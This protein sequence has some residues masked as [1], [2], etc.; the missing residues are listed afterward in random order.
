M[1]P[2]T[3]SPL[4]FHVIDVQLSQFRQLENEIGISPADSQRLATS[5]HEEIDEWPKESKRAFVDSRVI[6]LNAR[7]DELQAFQMWMDSSRASTDPGTVRARVI[8]QNYICFV[9]LNDACFRSL[10]TLAVEGSVTRRCADYLMR[11]GVRA[12]RN[13][14]AHSNW[15]Y[16][17]AFDGLVYWSKRKLHG[18]EP[19]LRFEVDQA[20]LGFW[21]AL[22]RTVA[23][24]SYLTLRDRAG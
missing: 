18:N 20:Q 2:Q 10:Q 5:I 23:Y 3:S 11:D 7:I 15:M 6:P 1:P 4:S 17:E 24:T 13:A 8:T 14:V 21:Q 22:S 16:N 12:L 9:Y 19:H